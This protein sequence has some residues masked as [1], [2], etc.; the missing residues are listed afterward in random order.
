MNLLFNIVYRLAQIYWFIFRPITLG[1]RVL[2][3]QD[4][5]VLLVRHTYQQAWFMP[6]GGVKRGETLEQAARR[7]AREEC[8]AQL[9]H[10][11]LLGV[12]THFFDFKSDHI[13]LFLS[14]EVAL[15]ESHS[16]EIERVAW[17]PLN[18]LPEDTSP[19]NRRR[20]EE[21]AR[22]ELPDWGIW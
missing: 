3:V 2:I 9:G 19:G 18:A 13:T 10:L 16:L 12:Y 17:F 8:G 22:G 11:R 20:I 15:E 14:D 1:V 6:G 21:F 4:G 5:Q 7:E